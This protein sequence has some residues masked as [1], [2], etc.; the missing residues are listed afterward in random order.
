LLELHYRAFK[1]KGKNQELSDFVSAHFIEDTVEIEMDEEHFEKISEIIDP[2]Q[3]G[4][5]T[6]NLNVLA[7]VP[8]WASQV[9]YYIVGEDEPLWLAPSFNADI[10]DQVHQNT[11]TQG[12]VVNYRDNYDGTYHFK[13]KFHIEK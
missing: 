2:N 12:R 7:I 9:A 3:D 8:K 5:M 11:S 4:S 13:L 10:L 6:D 1:R